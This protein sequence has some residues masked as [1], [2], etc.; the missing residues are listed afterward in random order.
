[1]ASERVGLLFVHGI[2]EQKR[3]E[4][5]R[6]SVR[7]L[8]ELIRC[9]ELDVQVSVV[10]R[11][12][13]W[14]QAPG[15]PSLDGPAPITLTVVDQQG[16]RQYECHEVWWADLGKRN[17]LGVTLAF[18]LWGLGQWAA[19]FYR[20]LDVTKT[21]RATQQSTDLS[22]LPEEFTDKPRVEL[23]TRLLLLWSAC[24]AILTVLS[25]SL[26]KALLRRI[27]SSVPSPSIVV[28]FLGDVQT[29][30][31]RA[32][33]N[34]TALSDPGHPL[35][36]PIRRR[37]MTELVAMGAR[38][39]TGGWYVLAHSLGT[40]VA[41]NGLTEIGHTLPNYLSEELWKKLPGHLKQPGNVRTRPL[42]EL[43]YMMPGR[44]GWL[45]PLDVIDR[46]S[47]FANLRGF[48]TYGSPLDKFAA[49]WPRII[50][51]ANDQEDGKPA[52]A[53]TT[54]WLNIAAPHDPV[55]GP[56]DAF[57][58]Q[59]GAA[60]SDS[61]LASVLPPVI[62]WKSARGLDAGLAHIRYLD[63]WNRFARPTSS[64]QRERLIE[65]LFGR[66]RKIESPTSPGENGISPTVLY[67]ALTIALFVAAFG[68]V[69]FALAGLAE[70]TKMLHGLKRLVWWEVALF[71]AATVAQLVTVAGL[72]RFFRDSLLNLRI[73]AYEREQS[74]LL[75]VSARQRVLDLARLLYRRSR[76]AL[77][78][79][80]LPLGLGLL[81]SI[82]GLVTASAW[83]P[84]LCG[85]IL[86]LAGLSV[87]LVIG[88]QVSL[89]VR[90][91]TAPPENR[92]TEPA[93]RAAA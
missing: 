56:L 12:A 37:M 93:A 24:V 35:R 10:D 65:W 40:V 42:R 68:T 34:R 53:P 84:W 26:A 88:T 22:L 41:Y 71:A 57:G 21:A 85:S 45:D 17:S 44:P 87:A 74:D 89:N 14:P 82:Y 73:A 49:I 9:S 3:F 86:V 25:W 75:D 76:A 39:Y 6:S 90:Y 92:Q 48:I 20:R 79:L 69:W 8:A 4:H 50:A 61:N 38:D 28:Q 91:K 1:M 52:F 19:P 47:L 13:D 66:D 77:I 18:W 63:S 80:A 5:L 11:T 81:A 67:L 62:N 29:F 27:T 30:E 15:Q 43:P 33:P 70:L 2:G 83:L 59:V 16:R 36:V 32:R 60:K 58:T 55:A 78:G 31:E 46:R 64:S 51:T 72:I 54:L 7:Q 23:K